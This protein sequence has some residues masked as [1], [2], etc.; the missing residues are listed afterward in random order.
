MAAALGRLYDSFRVLR[1]DA[2]AEGYVVIRVD[3]FAG[4]LLTP[5][6]RRAIGG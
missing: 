1:W 6:A 5:E 2:Q 3:A 4:S